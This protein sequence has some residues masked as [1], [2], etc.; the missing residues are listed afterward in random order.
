VG[1]A[2]LVLL[3]E[4]SVSSVMSQR[5]IESLRDRFRL[6][7][8][9]QVEASRLVVETALTNG[10][11]E[12]VHVFNVLWDFAPSGAMVGPDSPA[13]VCIQG[14]ELRFAR[15]SLPIPAGRKVIMAIDANATPLPAGGV[16]KEQMIFD[17]PVHEYSPYFRRSLDSPVDAVESSTARFEYGIA[18][19]A[20]EGAFAPA[21]MAGALRLINPTKIEGILLVQSRTVPCRT[22]VMR[23][24]DAFERF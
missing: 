5:N 9:V 11:A 23:R 14:N 8:N 24:R 17:V 19:G 6:D 18:V 2:G 15:R 21:P 1:A 22:Q 13:Y 16:L 10:T 20:K 12:T 4:G 7:L 3:G